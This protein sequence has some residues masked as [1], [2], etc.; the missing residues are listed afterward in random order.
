M[1]TRPAHLS[2][3]AAIVEIYNREVTSGVATFDMVPR[4]VAEQTEWLRSHAGAFPCIVA[5]DGGAP[6]GGAP[7]DGA[8]DDGA[9]DD[10]PVSGWACLSRY[11]PRPAYSTSVEDSVYV[12]PDYQRR[13]VGDLLLGDLVAAGDNLGFHSVFARIAGEPGGDAA[14]SGEASIALHRKHGFELVGVEREVGRKF[15]RW[16][17]VTLMQRLF[18]SGEQGG[19]AA[20]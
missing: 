3:A 16:L 9:P 2:D 1:F 11:R 7:D 12:H 6:D 10:D 15:G 4:T 13:G 18:V 19:A 8:P 14:V 5:V 20:Q 17:D